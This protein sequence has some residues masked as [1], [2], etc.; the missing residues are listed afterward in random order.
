MTGGFALVAHP[1]MYGVSGIVTF[2][3]N[4]DG[5]AYQKDLGPKT[6]YTANAVKTCN[7]DSTWTPAEGGASTR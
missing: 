7:P 2:V 1:A 6:T 4:Q 3:V 5:I